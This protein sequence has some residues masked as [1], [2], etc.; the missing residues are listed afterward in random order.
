VAQ[1]KITVL[2]AMNALEPHLSDGSR[3]DF[4]DEITRTGDFADA[5]R[6][7]RTAM[8][9][10]VFTTGGADINL[11][12]LVRKLDNRTRQDGFRVLHSWNHT[13]HRFTDDIVPVLLLD[14]FER[15]QVP[16]P[17]ERLS[18]G[19]LLDFYFLHLL[20]LCAM[21]VWDEG[22]PDRNLDRLTRMLSAL[23]GSDGSGHHFIADAET[24]LIY[25]LSQFHPEEQ[26]YDRLIAKVTTLDEV[27]QV[28]FARA[29]AA[30]LS[31][32]LRWGFWLM[33]ERDPVRMRGDNVGDYPWLLNSVLTLMR[34]YARPGA[35]GDVSRE[36]VVE[37]LLLGLAADPWAFTSS[38]PPALSGYGEAYRELTDLLESHGG[39][40]LA[41]FEACRPTKGSY[42]P[43]ALHFNFPHNTLV[44]IVTLAL[45]EGRSQALP[46]NALFTRPADGERDESLIRLAQTLMAFSRASPDRL[47]HQGAMLIA[48]D[49]LSGLRSFTLTVDAIRK[50]AG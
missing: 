4:L 45:L 20:A 8:A 9:A 10:H 21:R 3:A 27:R 13:T 24:L 32:H 33:Y 16:E 48:Y 26:A 12:K 50:A 14:F 15:A 37:A 34:A 22:D 7:L 19:I 41:D 2:D 38:A 35:S 46:L 23:H 42:S 31:A 1:Q 39:E 6:R 11:A 47:G 18:L 44:A 5:L 25:A 43:L 36:D 17:N 40:L 28:T 30:V 49:S 29:S